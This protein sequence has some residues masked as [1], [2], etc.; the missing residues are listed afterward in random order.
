MDTAS[1]MTGKGRP[2]IGD[3]TVCLNCGQLCRFGIGY[4]L[5][6]ADFPDASADISDKAKLTLERALY[7]IKRRGL[8]RSPNVNSKWRRK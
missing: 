4:V 1:N 5:E 7:F 2:E 6:V 8:Y 3:Y